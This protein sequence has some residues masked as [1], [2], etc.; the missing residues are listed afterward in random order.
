MEKNT[1]YAIVALDDTSL[2]NLTITDLINRPM[3][4]DDFIY[5]AKRYLAYMQSLYTDS[6]SN[7]WLYDQ[8]PK[9]QIDRL[10]TQDINDQI[11]RVL[12][13]VIDEKT[14]IE[15]LEDIG[16]CIPCVAKLVVPQYS[17]IEIIGD[18]HGRDTT[19]EDIFLSLQKQNFIDEKFEV[20]NNSR[21]IFLGDYTDRGGF[22]MEVLRDI[23]I[24]AIKNPGQVFLLRGNHES[25]FSNKIYGTLNEIEKFEPDKETQDRLIQNLVKIYEFMPVGMLLGFAG[26]Q[27]TPFYFLAHGGPDI[28]YD[29]TNLLNLN[30]EELTKN[31]GLCFWHLTK[32]DLFKTQKSEDIFIDIYKQIANEQEVVDTL[33]LHERTNLTWG[34]LWNDIDIAIYEKFLPLYKTNRRPGCISLESQFVQY[35]L[36]SFTN[37]NAKFVGLIR[38]HDHI[39]AKQL[40]GLLNDK[41]DKIEQYSPSCCCISTQTNKAYIAHS[42]KPFTLNNTFSITTVI[43]GPIIMKDKFVN[44]RPTF[45]DLR[46][47]GDNTWRFKAVEQPGFI[48]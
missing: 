21:I 20:F 15:D 30:T 35:F 18:I 17:H 45:L 47:M 39:L 44:Y 38:G 33:K 23:L 14:K 6:T 10:L 27:Q 32:E 7:K 31:G 40:V 13:Q 29:Y 12:A 24:L 3:N 25:I 37:E 48:S 9:D 34:F 42:G 8:C 41:N 19:I 5:L 4:S 16:P 43:S 11:T 36:E 26:P 46:F 2:E 22:S 28:R 1:N